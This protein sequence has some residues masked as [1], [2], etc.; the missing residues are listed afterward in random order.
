MFSIHLALFIARSSSQFF[1]RPRLARSDRCV[2]F[3]PPRSPDLFFFFFFNDTA[4]TEIYTLSLHD[5]LPICKKGRAV[6]IHWSGC[7]AGCGNHQAA[8]IGL[9]GSK[10]NV[11]GKLVDAVTIY[12]G[13]R[14]GRGANGR[15]PQPASAPRGETPGGGVGGPVSGSRV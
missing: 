6:S 3:F 13:G 14:A 9:R 10:I 7:P 1:L 5:A 4:T 8:D 15:N 12:T 2:F 11:D